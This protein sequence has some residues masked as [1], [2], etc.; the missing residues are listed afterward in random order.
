MMNKGLEII[1]AHYLVAMPE[2]QIDV[3]VHPESLIH[4]I[5]E[6]MD[7]TM[8]AQLAPNDMRFPILYAL[9]W[10]DRLPSRMPGLDLVTAPPMTFETPDEER[11]PSLK[12]ARAALRSGGEMP[13][14][15]NAA[16]EV[17]VSTFLDGRC[18]LPAIAMTV[19][20]TLH[21]WSAR[22]CPLASIEQALAA[23]RDARDVAREEI[24]KY[25]H[26]EVGS[27]NRC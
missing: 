8:I 27:E 9:S 17:A 4:S 5:V 3:V 23:D 2:D 10:P 11:F 26:A 1:E 7:G 19:E 14:V 12:L 21:R 24:R 13:A 16:N 6:Y 15:L 18:P 22:N 25:I 20:A